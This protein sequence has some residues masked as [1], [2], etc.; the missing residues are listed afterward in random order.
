MSVYRNLIVDIPKSHVTIEKQNGGKPALIK[1]VLEAPYDREKGYARPKR[2]TIG[3]QCADSL[4]TMHPTT[5]YAQ[6]FPS[7]WEKI[8]AEK[9]KPSIKKIGFF[10]A[11]QAINSMNGIKDI[12]DNVYGV[13]I[14][15]ALMDYAAYS[16]IHRTDEA[17]AFSY[18]M[19]NELLYSAEPASDSYYSRLFEEGMS[20]E[21]EILF[22][23]NWALQCKEDG[24]DK[25]WLCIDGSNDDCQSKGVEIAEKG[26][27]KSGK[28]IN[29]VSF[30]YAV[31]PEGK[32]VTY[33]V[34]RGGLVDAKAMKTILDFLQECGIGIAGVILDR[35][36]CNAAA[37][38][39]LINHKIAYVIMV[40]G[41]PEGY[42]EMVAEYAEKIKM[43]V[44]YLIPNTFLFG[45]QQPV[46]LFKNLNHQD[47]MTLFFDYR[48]G[49]E[50]IT[51]LLKNI[52]M[53]MHRL[54]GCIRKGERPVVDSKYSE[55]LSVV[56]EG[57]CYHVEINAKGLQPSI[58]E[59]G[60]YGI[61]T[62]QEMSPEKV[63]NLYVSRNASEIQY[64]MVKS[65]LGYG[66]VRVQ[67]TPGVHA[68]FAVGFIAS[69]LRYEVEK[70]S[71][72]LNRNANQ[73]ICELEQLEA[74]KLNGIYAYTHVE[75]ERIKSFF[76]LMQ[77]NAEQLIEE[78]VQYENDRLAGRLPTPR[79]RK[80]GPKK[81]SHRKQYDANGN[82]IPRKSGV[83]KGTKRKAFN[84][85][86]TPRKKPGV[87]PG[88]KR[89]MYN[90][91]G[92]IRK[93]PGPKPES[94][95]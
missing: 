82:I 53:E 60:L 9:I 64:R 75:N 54:E 38:Q 44:D 79:R 41:Q 90:K 5:Q 72:K 86:G 42:R 87:K 62:S 11:C 70:A 65:Q 25:V 26:H 68:R 83:A 10:S 56:G 21:Q 51:A 46:Q 55:F 85:D 19:R 15:N 80:T 89:G 67:N 20:K 92:S 29:I 47:Y 43:N 32:P 16:V 7:L 63:H 50:R 33:D 23:H 71:Q 3:H 39:Y 17:S 73:M 34:Y 88:T 58:N 13:N 94:N 52:Y 77:T 66:K 22:R 12:L 4:T 61:I 45:C 6:I 95:D 93:K 30:T 48:N 49:S 27:A 36:Y 57:S 31:T 81:G 18:K 76:H 69:I 8:S 74:Q 28:N 40:K 35:G 2:T 91:D 37:I 78:S 14:S 1:Y 84:Q 24:V 59:K